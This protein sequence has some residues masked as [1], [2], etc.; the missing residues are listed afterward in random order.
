MGI[1][2]IINYGVEFISKQEEISGLT[3]ILDID[4][5]DI[6]NGRNL[7]WN[8]RFELLMNSPIWGYG[9]NYEVGS[10]LIGV[11]CHNTI[12]QILHYGGIVGLYCFIVPMYRMYKRDSNR[13]LIKLSL[14]VS[15]L[16]PTFFIDTLQERTLWNF[17]IYYSLLSSLNNTEE[18]LIWD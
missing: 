10:S 18:G 14:F 12:L 8:V 11:A 15:V 6:S 4:N 7:I 3:R 16:L 1:G 17:I 5:S 13:P 2:F 9:A